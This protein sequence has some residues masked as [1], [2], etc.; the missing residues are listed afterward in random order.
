MGAYPKYDPDEEI[1]RTV[2]RARE[3]DIAVIVVGL[4]KDWEAET[5]DRPNLAL[6]L[7]Q[8]ELIRRVATVQPNT[9]V[10]VQ[11]G[12]AISMPWKDEVSAIVFAW[13][14]GNETGNAIADVLYGDYNPSGRLPLSFPVRECDIAAGLN[15]RSARGAVHYEEGIW[16]G[17][18]HHNA[19][20]ISPLFP[21]G[22]GLSYTSFDYSNLG[23]VSVSSDDV[24]ADDWRLKASV[25]VT[26]TGDR[27]GDH[28][29]HFYTTPPSATETSLTHPEVTLQA[30]EK[31]YDLAPGESRVLEVELDK[32][33]SRSV[34][35]VSSVSAD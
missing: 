33:K 1:E 13:Y 3:A 25:K 9:V 24:Q 16:V 17:Y 32:C 20:R 18:R 7:R 4:N 30:F 19:R 14:G 28:S 29:V 26:N 31:V 27:S 34:Q 2:R 8:N 11:G 12:S 21:F 35:Q 6:P 5:F 23:I 10:V 15:Y 22:H